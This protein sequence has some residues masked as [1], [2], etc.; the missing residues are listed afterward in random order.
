MNDLPLIVGSLLGVT[1]GILIAL[2]FLMV[3]VIKGFNEVISGLQSI[4]EQL[5]ENR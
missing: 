2:V 3:H 5:R 1:T 4:D